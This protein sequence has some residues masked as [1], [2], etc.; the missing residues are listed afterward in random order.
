MDV[1]EE[2]P[3]Q[4]EAFGLS[5]LWAI[6]QMQRYVIAAFIVSGLL[7]ATGYSLVATRYYRSNVVLHLTTMAGQEFQTD[8]VVDF[9]QYHRW[10]RHMFVR[11]QLEILQSRRVLTAVLQDYAEAFPDDGL[12]PDLAGVERLRGMIEVKA[13]Q[14]TELIDLAVTSRDPT[15]SMELANL[16]AETYQNN[17]LAAVTEAARTAKEWLA[18]QLEAK[19]DEISA[20]SEDLRE[21]QRDNDMADAEEE[22]TPLSARMDS[23]NEAY[24]QANTDRVLMETT[25]RNHRRLLR[26]GDYEKLSKDMNTPLMASLAQDYARA[27]TEQARVAAIYGERMPQRQGADAKVVS[28]E[29]EMRAEVERTLAA[30]EARLQI[31]RNKEES[32]QREIGGGKEDLL[33]LQE[34]REEYQK[35]RLALQRA[36]DFYRRLGQRRDELDLQGKTR[37]NNVGIVQAAL[38][39]PDPVEPRLGVNLA[40]GLLAGTVLGLSVGFLRE[41]LDDTITSPLEVQTFLKVPFLGMVPKIEDQDD[42]TDLALY[43]HQRPRSNVAEAIRATRTV[44]DLAPDGREIR[45]LLV[46]SAV[47]AEGKTSTVVRLGVAYANLGRRVLMIDCDLRRPRLHKIFGTQRTPGFTTIVNREISI[48]DA[49]QPS[50]I[51]NLSYLSSGRGGERP[52]ELLAHD[53]VRKLLDELNDRYDL[54]IVDSPPSVLLSDA[55]VLSRYA[56]GV[57]I[58]VREHA[59]P[60]VL[61]REAIQGLQQVNANILGVIVNAV[62]LSQRRSNYKYYYGYGYSYARYGYGEDVEPEPEPDPADPAEAA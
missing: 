12:R 57:V 10:N 48:E 54:V 56:D 2:G 41:Y 16:L 18:Q 46:T 62:D 58:L 36:Q 29:S 49:V 39:N 61:I 53:K 28:I 42:E 1:Q 47:Q 59:T 19:A 30:E 60:R 14:G 13:R 20:A 7:L 38:V 15:R 51:P 6:V 26:N 50:G 55:R 11:T 43:T 8:R 21:F 24:G 40:A 32:L 17:N 33:T 25:V 22:V 3:G 34:H 31:L 5:D 44:L 9:D 37:L 4:G 27:L 23:L 35:K 52:N 45:R